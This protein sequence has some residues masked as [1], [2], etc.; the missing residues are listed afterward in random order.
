[1]RILINF[2]SLFLLIC[3]LQSCS[4]IILKTFGMKKMK[5]LSK[6]EILRQGRKYN[7]PD[8]DAYELDSLFF[9]YLFSLD[10]VRYK[11]EQKNHFQPLQ[12]LYYDNTGHLK[13]FHINCNAGGFPNLKWNRFGTFDQFIPKQQTPVDSILPLE[14]HT[15]FLRSLTNNSSQQFN[16]NNYV[17][18]VHWSRFMGRQSKRLIKIVQKNCA[19][20]VDQHVRILYVNNDNVFAKT[21]H[22]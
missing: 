19:L 6:E 17:V 8:A 13:S 14:K 11:K 7:I 9:T 2:L 22:Y 18:I 21:E 16:E 10:S 5:E 4:P 12:A 3:S 20:G 1:M 15:E